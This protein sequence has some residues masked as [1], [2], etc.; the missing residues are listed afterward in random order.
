MLL[1]PSGFR[2]E[3][4]AQAPH[5]LG[6]PLPRDPRARPAWNP[7]MVVGYSIRPLMV[8][9]SASSMKANDSSLRIRLI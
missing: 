7:S 1:L 4:G 2:V 9:R 5:L 8:P 6:N 3:S